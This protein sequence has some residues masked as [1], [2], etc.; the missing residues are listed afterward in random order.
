MY[1]TSWYPQANGQAE[2]TNKKIL[3]TLKKRLEDAKGLW[4][5]LLPKVL[6]SF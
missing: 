2:A 4:P 3:D 6:W 1:S 5:E